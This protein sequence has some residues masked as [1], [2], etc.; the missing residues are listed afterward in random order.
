MS[1]SKLDKP[2]CNNFGTCCATCTKIVTR[3]LSKFL[4]LFLDQICVL[5]EFLANKFLIYQQ[6]WKKTK[7]TV[8]AGNFPMVPKKKGKHKKPKS[9][10]IC[11]V[12][13]QF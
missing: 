7:Q 11:D 8:K 5:G 2:G 6:L 10:V 4:I 3:Q 12:K 9:Q 13:T 1:K